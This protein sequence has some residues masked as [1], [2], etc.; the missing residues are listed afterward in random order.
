MDLVYMQIYQPLC[1]RGS[2][3]VVCYRVRVEWADAGVVAG[4]HHRAGGFRYPHR[5]SR[6]K[7]QGIAAR[8]TELSLSDSLIPYSPVSAAELW[9]GAR[10]HEHGR[11]RTCFDCS[12][13]LRLK[14]KQGDGPAIVSA[15]L[16]RGT[17]SACKARR[18]SAKQPKRSARYLL[19]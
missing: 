12:I 11:S 10:Q 17:V 7:E 14:A 15:N 19:R 9:A 6:R 3:R 5:I 2:L 4:D 16:A 1:V 13:V 18:D 8:W